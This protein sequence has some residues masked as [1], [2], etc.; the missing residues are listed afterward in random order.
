MYDW[1]LDQGKHPLV[2]DA[3]DYL[4]P[5]KQDL[6]RELC[7]RIPGFDADAVIYSWP[8]ATAEEMAAWPEAARQS[9]QTISGSEGVME[10]FDSRGRSL[11]DEV[12][13]WTAKYGEED[14]CFLKGLVESAMG[15]Y[16]YLRERRLR[17]DGTTRSK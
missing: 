13:K 15:D 11:D 5:E 14:A 17:P 2:L 7:Q 9:Q 10:G 8:K 4:G 6:M 3:D 16:E 12:A 1:Y